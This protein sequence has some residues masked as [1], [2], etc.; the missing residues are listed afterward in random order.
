MLA[1][2]VRPRRSSIDLQVPPPSLNRVVAQLEPFQR[3]R[4]VEGLQR[5]REVAL[6]NSDAVL[7]SPAQ[8]C[9]GIVMD[10]SL[11]D[12]SGLQDAVT[13]HVDDLV[14]LALDGQAASLSA[15][16]RRDAERGSF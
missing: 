4:L 11:R 9:V 3:E 13:H 10:Q 16:V 5:R 12:S 2:F 8:G 15:S 14:A 1:C 7:L 6:A